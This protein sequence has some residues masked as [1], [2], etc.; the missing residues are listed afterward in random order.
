MAIG[1]TSATTSRVRE[2]YEEYPYPP[3]DP[4]DESKRLLIIDMDELA[5]LNH[6]CYRGRRNFRR[7]F[8]VLVAGGGTG[9]ATVFLA[10]QLRRTNARIIHLDLSTASMGI[11]KE[12]IRVRGLQNRVRWING[13]LLELASFDLEPFDYINCSGVLHHLEDPDAGLAALRG[14]LKD[15]GAMGLMLYGK[16]ARAGVYEI[17]ELLRMLNCHE[18]NPKRKTDTARRI[19]QSLPKTNTL[20]LRMEQ[21]KLT[22]DKMPDEEI[23]DKFL[24]SQDRAYTIAEVHEFLSAAGLRLVEFAD[25]SRLLYQPEL[26]FSDPAL[27]EKV[28]SLP[29]PQQ[30]A[31]AE[32]FWGAM[33]KH[34]FWAATTEDT[35]A[36]FHDPENVPLFSR[37]VRLKNMV[38]SMLREKSGTWRYVYEQPDG[39]CVSVDFP[40]DQ[41]VRRMI[42]LI[43][44]RRSSQEIISTIVSQRLSAASPQEILGCCLG[45]LK[46]LMIFDF[47]L[48]RHKSTL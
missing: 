11:A 3:R 19:L 27:L 43:D 40:M 37:E 46:K 23:Y 13:S 38:E 20:R 25:R 48:F 15:D 32:I 7:G 1:E 45:A 31:A 41:N 6:H 9:D 16:H 21:A 24:H 35:T 28:R 12:R 39:I 26:A 4:A 17:Q 5:K 44:G 29:I 47:V 10:E 42:E 8:R 2:Q 18:E 22:V 14:A 33:P 30:H 36:N 34:T